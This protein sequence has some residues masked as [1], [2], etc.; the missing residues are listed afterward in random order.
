MQKNDNINTANKVF[1]TLLGTSVT[2]H[3]FIHE[4]IN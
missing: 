4:V 1:E 3:K 2:N